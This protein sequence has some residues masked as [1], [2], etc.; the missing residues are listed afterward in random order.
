MLFGYTK[1]LQNRGRIPNYP[2]DRTRVYCAIGDLVCQGT[3]IVVAPHLTYG[4]DAR[5][6]AASF[7]AGQI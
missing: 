6:P 3:L 7:L 5:G 4:D 1:N 2:A